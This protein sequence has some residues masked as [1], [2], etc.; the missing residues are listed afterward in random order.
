MCIRNFGT[1]PTNSDICEMLLAMKEVA[2]TF[3]KM[4]NEQGVNVV[5]LTSKQEQTF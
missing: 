5:V 4:Q 1:T 2:L 3:E